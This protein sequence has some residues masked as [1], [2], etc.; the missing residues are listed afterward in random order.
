M[1]LGVVDL[2]FHWPPTG[3]SW[4]EVVE[5]CRRL[6]RVGTEAV[7]VVP[8]LRTGDMDRGRLTED[9]GVRVLPVPVAARQFHWKALPPLLAA[10]LRDLCVNRVWVTNTF[11]LAPAVLAGLARWPTVW[12]VFGYEVLCPNYMSL[13]RWQEENPSGDICPRSFF[14]S[15]L[16]CTLCAIRGIGSA[17]LPG[18]RNSYSHEWI[19]SGA[20]LPHYAER[21]RRAVRSC[22]GVMVYNELART[23][24]EPVTTKAKVVPGGV[25]T[26]QFSPGE[27]CPRDVIIMAGRADDP[28]KGLRVFTDAVALLQSRG[29]RGRALATT[30][31]QGEI[32]PGVHGTG[33]IPHSGMAELYR[34][35][36]VVVVP[37]LWPEPF[38][39]VAVEAMACG[40]PVIA[41]SIGGLRTT[42]GRSGL[43]FPPGDAAS[44]SAVLGSLLADES[45]W[46][47]KA[48]Q[49]RA[50][51]EEYSWDSVV[52]RHHLPLLAGERSCWES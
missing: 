38:G 36:R 15:P 39:L 18:R 19:S 13:P 32:A 14:R 43:L 45:Y 11:N 25:D 40:R 50:I 48:G 35:A 34:M 7:V 9:P 51:A 41:S 47:A 27:S 8:Q 42:V 33:W 16:R 44:L 21:S 28:R 12:R 1:R 49:A 2:S 31:R 3:G 52:E 10:A 24:L 29:W 37:T 6:S 23:M 17:L 30:T 26:A 20:W 22:V 4:V 5:V 46:R